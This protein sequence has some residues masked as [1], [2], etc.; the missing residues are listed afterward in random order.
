[1]TKNVVFDILY[2]SNLC[3]LTANDNPLGEAV[4]GKTERKFL[5]AEPRRYEVCGRPQTE[6]GKMIIKLREDSSIGYGLPC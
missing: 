6:V 2:E 5:Y 3:T 1:M 4:G